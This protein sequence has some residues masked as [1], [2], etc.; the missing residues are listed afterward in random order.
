MHSAFA[1]SWSKTKNIKLGKITL[2]KQNKS[3][4]LLLLLLLC[5]MC[6]L[7]SKPSQKSNV[8]NGI[9][10]SPRLCMTILCYRLQYNLLGGASVH[11]IRTVTAHV[12]YIRLLAGK[13]NG[14]MFFFT[15]ADA[16][17]QCLYFSLIKKELYINL[18]IQMY[19]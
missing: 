16:L 13:I 6:E 17:V 5:F 14:I 11:S 10:D 8:I 19:V 1:S 18:G 12:D 2:N 7:G 9:Y 15:D 4:W 3:V